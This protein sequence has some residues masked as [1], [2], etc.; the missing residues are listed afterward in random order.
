[1]EA[2][3]VMIVGGLLDNILPS[4]LKMFKP[5]FTKWNK[6]DCIGGLN[7]VVNSFRPCFPS[8]ASFLFDAANNMIT[9]LINGIDLSKNA[10][11]VVG[12]APVDGHAIMQAAI[13]AEMDAPIVAG[14]R[15]RRTKAEVEEAIIKAGL[16]PKGFAPAFLLLLQF[17][18][19]ALDLVKWLIERNKND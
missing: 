4:I 10:P 19:L 11:L 1:M 14:K 12:A 15:K 8:M 5:D 9:D 6:Q 3:D 16:D 13:V 17:L 18:P 2:H 7:G